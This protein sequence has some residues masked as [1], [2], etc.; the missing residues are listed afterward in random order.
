L[1]FLFVTLQHVESDFYGRCGA[2]LVEAGHEVAHVTFSRRAAILLRRAGFDAI[3]LADEMAAPTDIDIAAEV[4][5]I[6]ETYPV[7]TFRDIYRTDIACDGLTEAECLARTVRH[8]QAVE[9][10][11]DRLR[12]DIVI[13]E[14]GNETIRVAAHLIGLDRRIPVLFLFHTIFPDP[15]R[16]TVDAMDLPIATLADLRELTPGEQTAV[17][18]F[19]AEYTERREVAREARESRLTAERFRLLARHLVVKAAWDRD[20]DYLRPLAWVR[21]RLW[22][23]LRAALARALYHADEP[24]PPFVYF[25]LHVADDY[26]VRRVIPHCV[27]QVSILEQVADALPHGVRLVAKEHP[28]SIGRTPLRLLRRLR[29][30]PNVHVVSPQVNSHDLVRGSHAVVV[31]GSTVGL[32]ALLYAKPVLTLGS[33]FYA[34]MGVTLDADSFAQI[35]EL[36]PGVLRFAPDAAAIERML[37]AAMRHCLPGAPVLVD[38]SDENAARLAHSLERGARAALDPALRGARP[39]RYDPRA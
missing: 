11:F 24:R 13:P 20:N 25:P 35:R 32:E 39:R 23:R 19:A 18:C 16:L 5:R 17:R 8:V 7:P 2:H 21:Q 14:V 22:E 31:I 9:R 37:G 12:P 15:L 30:L 34:G 38:R 4:A 1:R 28:M 36:V 6:T 29:R 27:D 3:C 26:K 33:P 10:A